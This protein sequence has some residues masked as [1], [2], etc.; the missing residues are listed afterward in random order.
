MTIESILK[1]SISE[2]IK[3]LYDHTIS[4]GEIKLQP[5]IKEYAG[6]HTFIIFP[7]LRISKKTPEETGEAI[8]TYI[9]N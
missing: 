8:G 4:P 1:T 6:T 3:E 7:F 9:H 5:T 2:A